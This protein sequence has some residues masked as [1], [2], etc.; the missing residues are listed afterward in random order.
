MPELDQI[1]RIVRLA[2]RLLRG[3]E[4]LYPQF[5]AD[6]SLANEVRCGIEQRCDA[7]H[8]VL[9][10]VF[11]SN[12]PTDVDE[13][14]E[15]FRDTLEL[16]RV[17]G[18]R[19]G[20]SPVVETYGGPTQLR[21]LDAN[22]MAEFAEAAESL[23]NYVEGRR[24]EETAEAIKAIDDG[25]FAEWV[26][27]NPGAGALRTLGPFLQNATYDD[28]MKYSWQ[29]VEL[30]EYAGALRTGTKPGSRGMQW[31][32]CTVFYHR[33]MDGD[34]GRNVELISEGMAARI[35]LDSDEQVGVEV[36]KWAR[37]NAVDRP[38]STAKDDCDVDELFKAVFPSADSDQ[39]SQA[40]TSPVAASESLR[41]GFRDPDNYW[42][43]VWLY[44]L[45]KEGRNNR[46][47][48][49]AL[50]DRRELNGLESDT[51]V[52]AAIKSIAEYHRWP[53]LEGNPGRP[54][55][56]RKTPHSSFG[57]PMV[58]KDGDRQTQQ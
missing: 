25:V 47:I 26:S 16:M 13:Q 20:G 37:E 45:R 54:P 36:L 42:R 24:A 7:L 30:F 51:A 14:I 56:N 52:R 29:E 34:C 28:G 44:D 21:R 27:R 38:T 46:E 57:K 58:K 32:S 33:E 11:R 12:D 18:Y 15:V 40:A 2:K 4:R 39:Q 55:A 3:F 8:W 48:R 19:D 50:S 9:E 31:V 35:V 6:P 1:A 17:I 23:E 5:D 10:D 43:N 53:L 22:M 49:E 41:A